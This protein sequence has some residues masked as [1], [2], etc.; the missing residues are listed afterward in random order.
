[1]ILIERGLRM[2]KEIVEKIPRNIVPMMKKMPTFA[3]ELRALD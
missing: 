3:P 2:R 1:M